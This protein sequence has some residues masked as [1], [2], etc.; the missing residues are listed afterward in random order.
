MSYCDEGT[1]RLRPC[2]VFPRNEKNPTNCENYS[3]DGCSHE[4]LPV[5]GKYETRDY[6]HQFAATSNLIP[7]KPLMVIVPQTDPCGNAKGRAI[8]EITQA[9]SYQ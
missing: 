7:S 4:Q 6:G 1:K 3:L 5:L 2:T 8:I 9:F